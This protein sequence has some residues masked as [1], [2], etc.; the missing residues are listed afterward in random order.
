[1]KEN[2]SSTT[3]TKLD[4]LA[5]L[6]HRV[7]PLY[8]TDNLIKIASLSAGVRDLF[9]KHMVSPN[10]IMVKHANLLRELYSKHSS[11]FPIYIETILRECY[12]IAR[13]EMWM[14]TDPS[15]IA[16]VFSTLNSLGF[17]FDHRPL[18]VFS[19]IER[20]E[21]D[22][23]MENELDR[24]LAK[25]NPDFVKIR[26]GAWET[27]NSSSSDKNR[28]ACNSIRELLSNVLRTVAPKGKTRAERIQEIC[29]HS[30]ESLGKE[31]EFIASF[32]DSIDALYG[33]LSKR[34]HWKSASSDETVFILK[35]TEYI[36]HFL[37]KISFS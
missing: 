34:T 20:D 30:K 18:K 22:V 9:T 32:S 14:R 27:F 36:L 28:Q 5:Y 31:A 16:N 8:I 21:I 7:F 12:L 17:D 24:F 2:H 6:L 15:R 1:M 3:E 26:A 29:R 11:S 25:L 13:S 10:H 19:L 35:S 33:L 23:D 37:L 4:R